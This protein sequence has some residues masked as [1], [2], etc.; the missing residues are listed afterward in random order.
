MYLHVVELREEKKCN[1]SSMVNRPYTS[2]QTSTNGVQYLAHYIA[3][4]ANSTIITQK[5]VNTSEIGV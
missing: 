5:I 4:I 3:K 1:T 2:G